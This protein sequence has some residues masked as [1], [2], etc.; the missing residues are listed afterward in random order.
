VSENIRATISDCTLISRIGSANKKIKKTLDF[1]NALRH[2]DNHDAVRYEQ[3]PD[4]EYK[5]KEES[6]QKT[7]QGVKK[8][9]PKK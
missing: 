6:N 3:I 9:L 1:H 8:W 5:S 2:I 4:Y 7:Y